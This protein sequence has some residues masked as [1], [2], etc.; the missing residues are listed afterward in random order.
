VL[1]DFVEATNQG[2]R[3]RMKRLS[4]ELM[5]IDEFLSALN[6]IEMQQAVMLPER[7]RYVVSSLF[8]EQCF[9]QLTADAD[10]QF[11]FITGAEVGGALVLDQ[12]IEFVHQRRTL[13]GVTGSMPDTHRLLI[14]LEAF[15]HKLLAHFHSHP[16]FGRSATRPSG[17]DEDFQ[18]RLETAG[19]PTVA[20]IFSRDGYIRFLRLTDMPTVQIYGEGV[21]HI[22]QQIYRLRT[23]HPADRQGDSERAHPASAHP[24][25]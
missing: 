19:Y 2:R 20:A 8:L 23:I 1:S 21:E 10:E 14:R 5:R 4:R 18:R 13:L 16:G 11:F 24:W 3:S 25:I 9:Q 12:R 17:I 22:D 15:G 6:R 7:R